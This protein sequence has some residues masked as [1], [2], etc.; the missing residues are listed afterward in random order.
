MNNQFFIEAALQSNFYQ[1]KLAGMNL[2]NWE[3]IP[4][5][6]KEELRNVDIFEVMGVNP[7]RI[8]TYHE[9]SGTTGI[10]TPSWFSHDDIQQEVDVLLRSDL[11]LN[12]K[13]IILN[14]FPFAVALPAFIVYWAVREVKAG[15]I[16]V[17]EWS[18]AAPLKRAVEII[19][20][21]NPTIL[22]LSPTEAVK[23][24]Q[25]GIQ[26]GEQFPIPGLRALILAGEL[27]SPARKKYIEKLWGVPVYLLFGSTETGGLFVT[28][29]AGHY[30]LN[31]PKLKV[32]AVDDEGCQVQ[33]DTI[34]NCVI[35]TA[36]EGM[37]LL[38]Y[39]NED[40]IEVKKSSMCRC[41][42][43]SPI[44]IHYGRKDDA[45]VFEGKTI[46]FLQVQEAVYSLSHVPF[47]WKIRSEGDHLVF[48]LQFVNEINID[49]IQSEL[50]SK[51]GISTSVELQDIIPIE[52]LTQKPAFGK[53]AYIEKAPVKDLLN[54]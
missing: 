1:K 5:T 38:R 50:S 39:Y 37:P 40:L 49:S 33:F 24:H 3:K 27:V 45:M 16:G 26:M 13:D 8:A 29:K 32:E 54:Q 42:N 21:V 2:G 19:Q 36:R 23:L 43:E 31:H 25:T 47:M 15:H 52:T 7:E 18:N 35:T 44:V 11:K 9:T 4:F 53:Y 34:G 17:D 22:A 10:P 20:K 48:I 6:T 41:C 14:R 12:E 46:N 51:L 28:C 30:H